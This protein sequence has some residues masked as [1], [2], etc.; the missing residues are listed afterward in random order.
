[1]TS[2][3]YILTREN[4]NRKISIAYEFIAGDKPSVAVSVCKQNH[5]K[6]FHQR[7]STPM[8]LDDAREHWRHCVTIG[9][10]RNPKAEKEFV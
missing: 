2:K 6:L 1:M 5:N 7:F 4:E 10:T 3:F 9:Y 8:H